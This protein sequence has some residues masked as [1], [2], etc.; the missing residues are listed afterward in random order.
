MLKSFCFALTASDA[1][2]VAPS[3]PPLG[4][5]CKLGDCAR[6]GDIVWSYGLHWLSLLRLVFAELDSYVPI[7]FYCLTVSTHNQ[8]FPN[9]GPEPQP[10][11]PKLCEAGRYLLMFYCFIVFIGLCMF[12]VFACLNRSVLP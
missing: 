11:V 5:G 4:D 8:R 2:T 12:F 10:E 1:F 7:V 9:C 3:R 6:Q